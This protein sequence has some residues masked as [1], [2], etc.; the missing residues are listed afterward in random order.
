RCDVQEWRNIVGMGHLKVPR[1]RS[2][3]AGI[4]TKSLSSTMDLRCSIV[5]LSMKR[6]EREI[7]ELPSVAGNATGG[8]FSVCVMAAFNRLAN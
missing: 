6:F 5:M 8:F 3:A 1:A 2:I 4:G 7:T